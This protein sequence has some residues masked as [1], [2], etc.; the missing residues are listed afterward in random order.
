MSK[1]KSK[2]T[3]KRR[4]RQ[5]SLRIENRKLDKQELEGEKYQKAL[6][7]TTT[8][9]N[10]QPIRIHY[11]LL[12]LGEVVNVFKELKCIDFDPEQERWLWLYK[13]EASKIKFPKKVKVEEDE[14]IILGSFFQKSADEMVLDLR[15]FERALEAIVF[16]DKHIPR[17]AAKVSDV[18][19]VN[20]LFEVREATSPNFD[21]FFK[22]EAVVSLDPKIIS[23]E[24]ERIG[25]KARDEK[26]KKALTREYFESKET[27]PLP[28]KE[29]LPTNF[30]EEGISQLQ[31]MLKSR[32][33][34]AK[35]HWMGNTDY[36]LEDSIREMRGRD[37]LFFEPKE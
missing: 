19:V 23:K 15:S 30:Y 14:A 25:L 34:M 10:F 21:R 29:R 33:I 20:R 36:T 35:Q 18:S 8:G 27:E 2:T 26:E 37:E 5:R 1:R 24:V 6:A 9:E 13:G 12:N 16:F 7:A 3:K 17:S 31:F 4:D 11:D 32:Q 22:G 28:E